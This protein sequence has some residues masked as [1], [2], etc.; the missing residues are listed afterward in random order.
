MDNEPRKP[1]AVALDPISGKH[2]PTLVGSTSQ[3]VVFLR[4]PYPTERARDAIGKFFRAVVDESEAALAQVLTEE[5]TFRSSVKQEQASARSIW[6]ARFGKFDYAA[7]PCQHLV[8]DSAIEIYRD[9]PELLDDGR[10]LS[11]Q[12]LLGKDAPLQAKQDEVLVRAHPALLVV[13]KDR[14]FGNEIWFLLKPSPN[15]YK[16]YAMAEDFGLP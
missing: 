6:S 4:T 12:A 2:S 9:T 3:G 1:P 11:G 8:E 5:A 15:G 13:G 10:S 7:L 16:I 14:V